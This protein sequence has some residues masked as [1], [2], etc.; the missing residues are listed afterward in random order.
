MMTMMIIKKIAILKIN[1][2]SVEMIF[3]FV[4]IIMMMLMINM[5]Y[6]FIKDLILKNHLSEIVSLHMCRR[7]AFD[8]EHKKHDSK[9]TV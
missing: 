5:I 4:V 8:Y 6:L 1:V 7:E 3:T 9:V 2:N